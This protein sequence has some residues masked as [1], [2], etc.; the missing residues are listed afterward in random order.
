MKEDNLKKK[1]NFFSE[2]SNRHMGWEYKKKR[3]R[4]WKEERNKQRKRD[5]KHKRV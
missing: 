5:W 3:W 4:D 1:R 2:N